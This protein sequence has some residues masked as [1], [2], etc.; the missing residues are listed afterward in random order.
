MQIPALLLPVV[1]VCSFVAIYLDVSPTAR[2]V[3][4]AV[5][6]GLFVTAVTCLRMALEVDADGLAVRHLLGWRRIAWSQ[7]ERVEI[8]SGIK[9]SESIRV[10]GRDGALIDVPPALVQPTFP[11]GRPRAQAQLRGT[12]AE[13]QSRRPGWFRP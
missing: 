9:G 5:G 7:V 2:G 8:A 1:C 13:I 6:L 4:A 11:T 12:L 10:V 3:L